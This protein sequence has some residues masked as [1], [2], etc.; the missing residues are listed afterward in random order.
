VFVNGVLSDIAI[1]SGRSIVYGEPGL[2]T[3][4]VVAIDTAGNR[5]EAATVQV[6]LP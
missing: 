4:E 1:G 2:N 5:S 3:I 6:V